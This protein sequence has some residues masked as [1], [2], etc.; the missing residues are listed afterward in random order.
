MKSLYP[1][2]PILVVPMKFIRPLKI[3][4]VLLF[5][6]IATGTYAQDRPFITTWQVEAGD[7]ITI[8]LDGAFTYNFDYTWKN[9]QGEVL[10]TGTHTS[11]QGDFITNFS[12]LE[13]F[14]PGTYTLEITGEF[15]RFFNYPKDRLLDVNQ[16]GDIAWGSMEDSFLVWPGTSFSATDAPDLNRVTNMRGMFQSASSFNGDLSSWDVSSVTDMSFMFSEASSFNR[17]LGNWDVSNVTDMEKMFEEALSFNGDLGSWDV[18]SVTDMSTMFADAISFNGDISNGD[19]SS[20]TD[21]RLMFFGADSF[22]GDLGSWDVSNVRTMDEMFEEALSFNGDLGSWD[23]SNVTNMDDMLDGSGLSPSNYDSLLIGW[24]GQQVQQNVELGAEGLIFCAGEEARGQLT[25]S[26][27]N[28]TITDAG[29]GGSA[30]GAGDRPFIT[31]WETTQSDR[32]IRIALSNAF[33]YNFDF[34]WKDSRSGQ[35]V[36]QGTHTSDNGN[37]N[38]NLSQFVPGTYILEISG[39]F[40]RFSN[41]DKAQLKDVNQWGD[42]AWGS[43]NRSFQNWPGAGFSAT[44]APDLSAVTDM[45]RMFEGTPFFNDDLSSWDVSTIED[46]QFMFNDAVSF[47]RNLISWDVSSVTNMNTMF[48]DATSF[49]GDVSSWD[50]SSVTNMTS[51]L[52]GSGLSVANY[53][54][55]LI[56]WAGQEV[57]Q[58]ISFGA[59]G[60]SFCEGEEARNQLISSPNNWR[61]TDEGKAVSCDF[62]DLRAFITTWQVEAGDVIIIPMDEGFTY[63]FNFVWKNVQNEVIQSGNHTSEE[64]EFATDFSSVAPGTYILEIK[65]LFP[66]FFGY[67]KAQLKDV[68]QWGDIAWGSMQ[69]SFKDWPG[70]EFSATDVPNLDE[71]TDLSGMLLNAGS[72]NGDLSSWDVSNVTDMEEM[73]D[74]TGLSVANYDTLLIGWAGQQVQQN[75]VLGAAGLVFCNAEEAVNTLTESFNWTINDAGKRCVDDITAFITTWQTLRNNTQITIPLD[76]NFD[77]EFEYVWRNIRTGIVKE[78]EHTSANGNFRTNLPDAS[79]HILEIRRPGFPRFFDYNKEALLDVNQWGGIAWGSMQESFKDWLGTGFS[80]TDVPDLTQVRDMSGMFEDADSFD[81]DVSSWDVGNVTSMDAMFFGAA[82]F[83]ADVSNWDV[84]KVTRMIN[85][86][87]RAESFN[88][89]LGHWDM[90]S[91][92]FITNMLNESGLSRQNYDRTLI[93]WSE[94]Q[95]PTRSTVSFR[96]EGLIYCAAGEEGARS[97]LI[98]END[99]NIT[100]DSKQCPADGIDI[101]T[102]TL[103]GQSRRAVFDD[104]NHTVRA[105]VAPGT[106]RSTLTPILVLASSGTT[107][108][109]ASEETVDFTNPVTYTV[110]APNGTTT[111]DW[112]VQVVEEGD[113]LVFIRQVNDPGYHMLSAPASGPLFDE[114]LDVFWTQGMTGAD[115][116]DGVSNLY[117]WDEKDNKWV[118]PENLAAKSL[119][120]GQGFLF[121]VYSDDNGPGEPGDTGF[122]KLLTSEGFGEDRQVEVNAGNIT[123]VTDLGDGAF[124]LAGNPYGKP[125]H[126]DDLTKNDLSETVYVYDPAANRYLIYNGVAGGSDFDGELPPFQ[127]FFVQGF[128]EQGED[129]EGALTFTEAAI[130]EEDS[131]EEPLA[132]HTTRPETQVLGLVADAEAG[133]SEAWVSFQKGG[134]PGRDAHDGLALAPMD[135]TYLQLFTIAGENQALTIHALPS[136]PEEEYRLPL[137]LTGRGFGETAELSFTGLE[138]FEGWVI[139]LIDTETGEEYPIEA[140]SRIP[141]NIEAGSAKAMQVA[142]PVQQ[143]VKSSEVRYELVLVPAGGVSNDPESELPTKVALS[144]N[145]PNPFNPTTTIKYE[146]PVRSEVRLEIYDIVG[147]KVAT[148][149]SGEPQ[150]AGRYE[151]RFDASALASG[152][153]LYRLETLN[154]NGGGVTIFTRKMMLIK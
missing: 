4:V 143:K 10:D 49:N 80:A 138:A 106:D 37:F 79:V 107:S 151:V 74:G 95:I 146:L 63:N 19:V 148:L 133:S 131:A 52:N 85:M 56:G 87:N 90:S 129:V 88:Q 43:M 154:A 14:E 25:S 96:A 51:M 59:G 22:N 105:E 134:K 119:V 122:P 15:P 93:S 124:F 57:Q 152:M 6:L 32:Q 53:D 109:P 41:Y 3:S 137:G 39:L 29:G 67:D 112:T 99:W 9:E 71:V 130:V 76:E 16:W 34:V 94:Q 5:V 86:F 77:Y 136:K 61:I 153:Y 135:T 83:N 45:Q 78:G 54:A 42:I 104:D 141:L 114:L 149:V 47:N 44:D 73:L 36:R 121:F 1:N 108:I 75:V 116:E 62:N 113:P 123:A 117:T 125:V 66:R 81:G 12:E 68:N 11:A 50:V 58:G 120:A 147:R 102:F 118:A 40:P 38:K 139:T 21:M 98:N 97:K 55:L 2:Y 100:G 144:Q 128:N 84:S 115:S 64:G 132:K 35:V 103:P 18:S 26:P 92:V 27:N 89:D 72:F 145:F 7:A 111:Q 70:E 65:G 31:T 46:M 110:T 142:T 127:G 91:V 28:W 30:C 13:L 69:E 82:A 101:I 140:G 150:S 8:L 20:V 24:A 23:V 17:N 60:L 126:W 33:T 48:G